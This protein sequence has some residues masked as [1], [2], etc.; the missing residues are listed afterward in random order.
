M[1]VVIT[2]LQK[3]FLNIRRRINQSPGSDFFEALRHIVMQ[4]TSDLDP[5]A[6]RSYEIYI[7]QVLMD[8][9]EWFLDHFKLDSIKDD[10]YTE[11][12]KWTKDV[13]KNNFESYIKEKYLIN[14]KRCS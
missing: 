10:E 7:K 14:K 1:K 11:L 12:K 9:S 3:N 13:I 8:S 6:F 2:E 4:A 5:C